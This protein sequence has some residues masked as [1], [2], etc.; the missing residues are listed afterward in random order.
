MTTTITLALATAHLTSW[1]AAD[2]AVTKGQSYTIG[3]RTLSRAHV[4]E[5]RN[6]INYWS[7][8]EASLTRQ[9]NGKASVSVSLAKFS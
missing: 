7:K 4:A 1:L 2:T 3:D 5:I 6:Q 9:A 8:M